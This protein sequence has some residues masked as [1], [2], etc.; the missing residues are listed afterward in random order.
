[1]VSNLPFYSFKD[2]NLRR[3]VPFI[4]IAIGALLLVLISQDPPSSLF[5]IVSAYAL[6]GYVIFGWQKYQGKDVVLFVE[7]KSKD[8]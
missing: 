4:F 8:S 2:I 6:S 7:S 3:S 1:M 5:L